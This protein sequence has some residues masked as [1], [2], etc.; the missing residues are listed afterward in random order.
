MS[1]IRDNSSTYYD[2]DNNGFE[3]EEPEIL[4]PSAL[5]L[6]SGMTFNEML[7]F[8][9]YWDNIEQRNTYFNQRQLLLQNN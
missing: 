3:N 6:P 4:K 7:E 5:T 9:P 1:N 2:K 8:G